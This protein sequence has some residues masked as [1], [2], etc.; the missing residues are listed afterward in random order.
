[1]KS[2]KDFFR[3]E[4]L[5]VL[6]VT[7]SLDLKASTAALN[8][9]AND[10]RFDASTEVLLDLRGMECHMSNGDIYALATAMGRPDPLLPTNKKIAILVAGNS[11]FNHAEFL[12]LCGRSRGLQ[13]E[14]FDDYDRAGFWLL[15]T[16]PPDAKKNLL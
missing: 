10:P 16:L 11:E 9:L 13:I 15:G 6:D 7:G 4:H 5:V 8:G 2:E 12:A 3:T 14:A 1:L